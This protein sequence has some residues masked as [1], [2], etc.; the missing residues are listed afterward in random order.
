MSYRTIITTRKSNAGDPGD[1]VP[2]RS[3]PVD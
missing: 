1:V 2:P 3:A